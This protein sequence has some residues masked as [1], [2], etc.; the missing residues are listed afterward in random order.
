MKLNKRK[1]IFSVLVGN[2]DK[3]PKHESFDSDWEHILFTDVEVGKEEAKGWTISPLKNVIKNDPVKTARWHKINAH[4]LFENCL[5]SI[6]IDMNISIKSNFIYE[7][8]SELLQE[9]VFIALVSHPLRNCVYK[10]AEAC[11]EYGKDLRS[12]IEENISFLTNEKFPEE[13]GLYES[14]LIFRNHASNEFIPFNELW[15]SLVSVMSRRDQLSLTYVLWKLN[16]KPLLFLKSSSVS[17]RN[18]EGF[19]YVAQH[20]INN[21]VYEINQEEY[22][23]FQKSIELEQKIKK[24]KRTVSYKVFYK[25]ESFI[26]NLFR[27]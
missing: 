22:L 2:Y 14:N 3:V 16:I 26:Y 24:I 6:F 4:L 5:C 1:I 25:I 12:K 19:K 20:S 23:Q 18:H 11:I 10:E 21:D 17:M 9:D 15:W 8:A 7:R 13:Y 27:G